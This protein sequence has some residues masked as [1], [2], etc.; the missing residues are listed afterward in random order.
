MTRRLT[1]LPH[2]VGLGDFPT[3]S[4]TTPPSP[5]FTTTKAHISLQLKDSVRVRESLHLAVHYTRIW[6]YIRFKRMGLLV[7]ICTIG[8][9]LFVTYTWSEGP[10]IHCDSVDMVI[11]YVSWHKRCSCF[12]HSRV[13]TEQESRAPGNTYTSKWWLTLGEEGVRKGSGIL[14]W[15]TMMD[16]LANRLPTAPSALLASSLRE[17]VPSSYTDKTRYMTFIHLHHPLNTYIDSIW[18]L[19]KE[20]LFSLFLVDTDFLYYCMYVQVVQTQHSL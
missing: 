8:C 13:H 14:Y 1:A 16:S 11:T 18:K 6:F 15:Q 2:V 4:P 5:P 7:G 12:F 10:T 9:V 3:S 20:K 17:N 19:R